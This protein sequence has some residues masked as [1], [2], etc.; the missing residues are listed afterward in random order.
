MPKYFIFCSIVEDRIYT[1]FEKDE[2]C[3]RS[4]LDII[5][6]IPGCDASSL[7]SWFPTFRDDIVDSTARAEIL[8]F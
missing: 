5:S 4:R 3:C 7:G 1:L 2:T 8:V 6:I